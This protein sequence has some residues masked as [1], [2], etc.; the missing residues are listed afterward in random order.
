MTFFLT[1]A[2]TERQLE[3]TRSLIR[4]Y[5]ETGLV[6]LTSQNID[7]EIASLPGDYCQ[8]TGALFLAT[9]RNGEAAGCVAIHKIGQQGDAEIKRLFVKP[10]HRGQSLGAM[11]LSGA[12]GAAIQMEAK[13]VVLD[14]MPNM[15]AAIALYKAFGFYEIPPYWDNVLP[16]IYFGKDLVTNAETSSA[17]QSL[18]SS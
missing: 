7:A 9:D 14:T 6:D 8:P 16:V 4:A 18:R 13:R 10:A 2:S 17:Q 11:L 1:L 12:I 5:V 15:K 3:Q